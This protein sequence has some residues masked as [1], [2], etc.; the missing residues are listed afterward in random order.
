M[1]WKKWPY[2]LIGGIIS[3]LFSGFTIWLAFLGSASDASAWTVHFLY[4]PTLAV[5]K[6]MGCEMFQCP[7]FLDI[8][9]P[10]LINFI[11]GAFF[12]WLYGKIKSKK[13]ES[14]T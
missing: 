2:W 4:L 14:G 7:T 1:K 12:G 5:Y 10:F 11:I 8:L 3:L 13:V 6:L 9:L